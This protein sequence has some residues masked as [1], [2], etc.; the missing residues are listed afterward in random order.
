MPGKKTRAVFDNR[1]TRIFHMEQ[2]QSFRMKL[3]YKDGQ[4]LV[5][6]SEFYMDKGQWVPGHRHFYL[7]YESWCDLMKHIQPFHEQV[8]KGNEIPYILPI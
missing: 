6:L 4:P 1:I 3:V 7:A 8:K 2:S 5:G